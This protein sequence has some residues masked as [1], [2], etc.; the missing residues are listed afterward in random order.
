MWL[1]TTLEYIVRILYQMEI[2]GENSL[3]NIGGEMEKRAREK[4]ERDISPKRRKIR[5]SG[6]CKEKLT[7][8][9]QTY[10][11]RQG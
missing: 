6:I 9:R 8:E 5:K 2:P 7:S 11:K 4:R 1:F 3:K 10:R